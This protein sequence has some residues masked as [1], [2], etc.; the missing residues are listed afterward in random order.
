MNNASAGLLLATLIL[1]S[2]AVLAEGVLSPEKREVIAAVDA[3]ESQIADMSM[4]LWNY[5]EI[6]LEEHQS[7]EYLADILE[8][9]GFVVERAVADM[10][11]AFVAEWGHSA[12]SVGRTR[13]NYVAQPGDGV[14]PE[15]R[16]GVWD[17]FAVLWGYRVIP[18]ATT[19]EE[20]LPTLNE[21]L[22]SRADAPAQNSQSS[23]T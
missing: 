17:K 22:V 12:S 8:A 11:T 10:P 20:E 21:W 5:S 9:E 19:P 15:R 3:L 6:A 18:G 1:L 13:F 2:P 23:S 4:Q 14:P 7:A 16:V